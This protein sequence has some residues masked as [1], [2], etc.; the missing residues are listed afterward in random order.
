[1]ANREWRVTE[2]QQLR[3]GLM[4]HW[5]ARAYARAAHALCHSFVAM[6]AALLKVDEWIQVYRP[7]VNLFCHAMELDLKAYLLSRG[8]ELGKLERKPF[9]HDLSHALATALQHT[10]IL[11]SETIDTI[12][13][14][15]EDYSAFRFRYPEPGRMLI[16][17]AGSLKHACDTLS[18]AVLPSI[19]EAARRLGEEVVPREVG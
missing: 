11:D 19:A 10:L 1:L 4:F 7:T 3:S 16:W 12:G 2:E 9:S 18:D 14:I 8:L 17:P 15:N 5:E 13:G 6:P